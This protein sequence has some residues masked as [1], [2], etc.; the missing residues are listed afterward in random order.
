MM[1]GRL[2]NLAPHSIV[3]DG[4]RSESSLPPSENPA[5]LE[6]AFI[7]IGDLSGLPLYTFARR[8][9]R[10]LPDP[11]PGRLLVVSSIVR[12]ALPYRFDLVSPCGFIRDSQGRITAASGICGSRWTAKWARL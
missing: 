9:P 1:N 10:N 7:K 2:V 6:E 12:E 11:V 8:G 3:F 5:R 4:L